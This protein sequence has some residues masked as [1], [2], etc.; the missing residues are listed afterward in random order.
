MKTDFVLQ[1]EFT[2]DVSLFI[3]PCK[4]S[5]KTGDAV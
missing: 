1:I 2:E 4:T 3:K 5:S